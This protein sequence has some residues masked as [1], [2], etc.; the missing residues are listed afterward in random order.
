MT[1]FTGLHSRANG[2]RLEPA[3]FAVIRAAGNKLNSFKF[4]TLDDRENHGLVKG[5][6]IDP[7]SCFVRLYWDCSGFTELPRPID[8]ATWFKLPIEE[9][10]ADGILWF[11]FLNEPNLFQ[12]WKWTRLEFVNF[13][14]TVVGL[15]KQWFPKARFISPG[16]SP[17][18]NTPQWDEAFAANGLYSVFDGIGAHSYGTK[19]T[20]L[21]N[22]DELR[23]YRRFAKRLTGSQQIWITE[24][25]FK[26]YHE[27]MSPYAVGLNYGRYA[28]SLEPYVR[29]V[30]F[31]VLDGEPFN[32][33]GESWT[34][35]PSIAMGLADYKGAP[36]PPPTQEVFLYW[37]DANTGEI[38]S[39]DNPATL[40]ADTNRSLIPVTAPAGK[41]VLTT[42][43]PTSGKVTGGGWHEVGTGYQ[44]K[45]TP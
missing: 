12:E 16:L 38:V 28:T 36:V 32:A 44:V 2:G 19:P 45:W 34:A 23:Y 30:W 22:D 7:A 26:F 24:A 35:Q 31:F 9:A 5:L 8:F 39:R 15:F 10:L 29:G 3:D 27:N 20:D 18:P 37:E 13:A 41:K 43:S 11:E 25:S 21:N 4:T 33:S 1:Q 6:G 40:I 42:I 14:K 17:H